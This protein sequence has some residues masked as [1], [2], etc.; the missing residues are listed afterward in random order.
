M[1]LYGQYS[2]S[3][4]QKITIHALELIFLAVSYW[5]LFDY[6]KVELSMHRPVLYHERNI[7][8]FVFNILVFLR[9]GYMMFFLLKRK[10]PWEESISVPMAFALYYI[11]FSL[12][13]LPTHQVLDALDYAAIAL[14]LFGSF[15]NT[16]SEILRDSW[17]KDPLNKGKL[18]TSG[19][20]KYSRHINYFGDLLWV[21][22][23][24]LLTKNLYAASIPIFL[25]GFFAFYNAPKLDA[26]LTEKYGEEYNQYAKKTKML[27]PFLF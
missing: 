2:K 5:I 18:Y 15:L 26:Y 9:L 7:I 23:Y 3:L 8:L 10:I 20:F 11:G 14:F 6:G 24:A 16:G 1:E 12:F 17:K 22:A 13:I 19:L 21:I 4:P 25:F 27:V